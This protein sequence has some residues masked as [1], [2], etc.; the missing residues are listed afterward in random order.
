MPDYALVLSPLARA[1]YFAQANEV[2]QAEVAACVPEAEIRG[3][4]RF[5]GLEVLRLT[6]PEESLPKLARMSSARARSLARGRK[7]RVAPM[8][9]GIVVA[10]GQPSA[11]KRS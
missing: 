5:G 4:E 3:A 11:E 2:V 7:I 8:P 10:Q 6:A 9:S 1:A